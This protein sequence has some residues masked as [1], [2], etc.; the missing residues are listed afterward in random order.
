[1]SPLDICSECGV[2]RKLLLPIE[3]SYGCLIIAS[4]SE[5]DICER[6]LHRE[7]K[8]GSERQCTA[9]EGKTF[10]LII[11]ADAILILLWS[12][13]A[14]TGRQVV[15]NGVF[16]NHA[17]EFGRVLVLLWR[18]GSSAVCSVSCFPVVARNWLGR[19]IGDRV[20]NKSRCG[21]RVRLDRMTG[22]RRIS[23]RVLVD[24]I[25]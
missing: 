10:H 6:K 12:A 2:H 13:F 22:S 16:I 9:E 3:V 15:I 7:S 20:A 8:I 21:F 24:G 17:L 18:T 25:F 11:G 4:I 23:S 19:E 5:R 14:R 1:M